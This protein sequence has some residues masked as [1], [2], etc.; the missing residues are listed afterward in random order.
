MFHCVTSTLVTSY[1]LPCLTGG[2]YLLRIKFV[3]FCIFIYSRWQVHSKVEWWILLTSAYKSG[4]INDKKV[5]MKWY[6]FFKTKLIA[7]PLALHSSFGLYISWSAI[8]SFP[9]AFSNVCL[10]MGE[11]KRIRRHQAMD[12]RLLMNVATKKAS[13]NIWSHQASA[14]QLL[15]CRSRGCP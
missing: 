10:T 5:C 2:D 12:Q 14:C 1:S 13:I 7:S 15:I 6:V 9:V 4:M 8:N 3:Y 11:K